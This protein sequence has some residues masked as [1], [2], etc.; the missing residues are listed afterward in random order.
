[1]NVS[2]GYRDWD[3]MKWC[4]LEKKKMFV[5]KGSEGVKGWEISNGWVVWLFWCGYLVYEC[6]ICLIW[7]EIK[8]WRKKWCFFNV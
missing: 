8:Y 2:K 4:D 3:Y 6:L 5:K 1:M 7:L